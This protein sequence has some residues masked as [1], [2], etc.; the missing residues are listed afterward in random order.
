[1]AVLTM[2]PRIYF[3][4]YRYIRE[5]YNNPRCSTYLG[6]ECPWTSYLE[7][8]LFMLDHM[9]PR[10]SPKHVLSRKNAGQH[11]EPGNIVWSLRK[12]IARRSPKV[13]KQIP[14]G[15]GWITAW[16]YCQRHNLNYTRFLRRLRRG[17][18]VRQARASLS[19]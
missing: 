13:S 17:M 5:T 2:T 19:R 9:P 15:R 16:D 3:N 1:M 12:E 7:F 11:W 10:P 18:T 4:N 6:G 14:M 8:Y